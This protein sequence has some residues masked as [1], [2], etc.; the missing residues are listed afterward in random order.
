LENSFKT[1]TKGTSKRFWTK[2]KKRVNRFLVRCCYRNRIIH[3]H[4]PNSGRLTGV[5]IPG[6][7]VMLEERPKTKT[8]YRAIAAKLPSGILTSLD[9][10]LPNR[11]FQ[12]LL[13]HCFPNCTITATNPRTENA[14][15]FVVQREDA[16]RFAPHRSVDSAFA[17][18]FYVAI[19]AGV[20]FGVV[21]CRFDGRVL[22][23][24]FCGG[25]EL[26]VPV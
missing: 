24:L 11:Q 8:G 18:A 2:F 19:K 7:P 5:L 1:E 23:P 9:A 14:V 10:H 15:C 12:H 16:R 26:L 3:A 13:P 17:D 6:T 25:T 20:L 4:L 22:E 21:I